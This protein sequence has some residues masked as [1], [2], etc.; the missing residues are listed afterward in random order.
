M[1]VEEER[2]KA[3]TC[4]RLWFKIMITA[5]QELGSKDWK[6]QQKAEIWVMG[7]GFSWV[8]EVFGIGADE[9]REFVR[10]NYWKKGLVDFKE[11]GEGEGGRGS[12]INLRG[13]FAL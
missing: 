5:L 6:I 11:D 4:R 7:N 9:A 2:E 12:G 8:C 3:D 1:G 10:K 13:R